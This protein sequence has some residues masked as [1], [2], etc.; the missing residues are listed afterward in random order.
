MLNVGDVF[1]FL[2]LPRLAGGDFNVDSLRG[3]RAL[4]FWWGSW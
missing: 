3:K 4:L 2:I 1:P